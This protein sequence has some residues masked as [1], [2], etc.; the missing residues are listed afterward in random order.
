MI[1]AAVR[2]SAVG[3]MNVEKRNNMHDITAVSSI[4]A[5]A[6]NAGKGQLQARPAYKQVEAGTQDH[7][8]MTCGELIL[9]NV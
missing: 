5:L 3:T 4:C 2:I 1:D 8:L 9:E 6:P 7:H